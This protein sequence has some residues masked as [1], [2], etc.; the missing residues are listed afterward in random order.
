MVHQMELHRREAER[1]AV[2]QTEAAAAVVAGRL[3]EARR[4]QQQVERA[5]PSPDRTPSLS[6][7]LKP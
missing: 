6:P 5:N 4:A 7:N 1:A 2:E 3:H